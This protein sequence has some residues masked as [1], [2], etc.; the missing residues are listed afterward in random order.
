MLKSYYQSLVKIFLLVLLVTNSFFVS[1]QNYDLKVSNKEFNLERK[2]YKGYST[3][4][5]LEYATVKREWWKYI[6]KL[7]VIENHKLYYI[8]TFPPEKDK[9]NSPIVLISSI[10]ENENYSVLNSALFDQE[11]QNDFKSFAK[12]ILI[13]FKV[14]L[15]TKTIQKK[16][17]DSEKEAIKI[18]KSID[19]NN[20]KI[21]N[22]NY[23]KERGRGN[24]TEWKKNISLLQI[25]QDS[26]K[27]E[28]ISVQNSVNKNKS[29]LKKIK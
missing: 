7:A 19:V 26:L 2:S 20:K 8:T 12:N 1:A 29:L 13:D 24:I 6:K 4:L 9:S 5:N 3:K 14:N 21:E 22:Y 17:V 11:M 15:F 10:E 23:K 27:I 16:I 28:L 18:S 25:I